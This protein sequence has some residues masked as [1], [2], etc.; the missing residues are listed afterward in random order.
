MKRRGFTL[1]E[2]LVVITIIAIL[3]ALLLPAVQA[4][5]RQANSM[6]S[7]NN[8]KQIGLAVHNFHGVHKKLPPISFRAKGWGEDHSVTLPPGQFAHHSPFVSI[9]PFL[10]GNAISSRYDVSLSPLVAP[11]NAYTDKPLPVYL[12]PEMGDPSMPPYTAVSSYAFCRGNVRQD[13]AGNW[14]PDDGLIVSNIYGRVQ[15]GDVRDGT[16]NTLL[17]GEMMYTITGWTH[18]ATHA[19]YPS[20]PKTGGTNWVWGHPGQA[21]VEAGTYVP[22]NTRPYVAK[23]E[24]N[25]WERSGL[26]AF[27]SINTNGVNFVLG[28]GAVKFLN[29][30]MDLTAYRALGSR[31]GNEVLTTDF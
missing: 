13:G 5:R 28:D 20:Q 1:I 31:A 9:L 15:L 17:A 18:S 12:S 25:Y 6:Q 27:R 8:L 11:N 14:L 24:A 30:N 16:S 26:Y 7:R 4:I 23:T 29:V 22:M 3:I 19:L 10:E 2:L 21:T